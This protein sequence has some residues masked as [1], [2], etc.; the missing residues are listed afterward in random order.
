VVGTNTIIGGGF[1]LIRER[2]GSVA[3]WAVIHAALAAVTAAV[4]LPQLVATGMLDPE[5][6]N[7]ETLS[8]GGFA[9][10]GAVMG[11]SFL[12][13][14]VQWFVSAVLL[15]A[16]FRAVLR[17]GEGGPASLAIGMDEVRVAVMVLIVAFGS[18]FALVVGFLLIMLVTMVIGFIL[19][20]V[21]AVAVLVGVALM[22]AMC[23]AVV[24][25]L[26]RLSLIYPLTFV[27]RELAIDESWSLTRGHFWNLFAAYLIIFL[28]SMVLS[29]AVAL[30]M[31]GHFFAE[32]AR[33]MAEPERLQ[34][35]Q[36]EQARYQLDMPL[37]MRVLTIVAGSAVNA[38][39]L[40]LGGGALA[41]ATRELLAESGRPI[42]TE[43]AGD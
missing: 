28:I 30:P 1:K 7:P 26:V 8:E 17:P 23:C 41:T 6:F 42:D 22:L 38:L 27:R 43:S 11:T 5:G 25:A 34:N 31:M 2:P 12:F 13:S 15:C 20:D 19:R 29:M 36:A 18:A 16:A 9:N 10:L 32:L 33:G 14:I 4:V 40:A 37:P 39:V 24:L 21:P 3:I 35:L